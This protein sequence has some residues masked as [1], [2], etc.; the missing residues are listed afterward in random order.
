MFLLLYCNTSS[1]FLTF[2]IFRELRSLFV[3]E[4][5]CSLHEEEIDKLFAE[6]LNC[7]LRIS[8][9]SLNNDRIIVEEEQIL[10]QIAFLTQVVWTT[11]IKTDD[12]LKHNK[13]RF[14]LMLLSTICPL[15]LI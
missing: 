5:V 6:S 7:L 11:K 12:R 3:Y 14:Q 4:F 8:A 2:L 9:I 1:S 15:S 10:K 13:L